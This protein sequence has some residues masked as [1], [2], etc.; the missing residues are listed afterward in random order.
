MNM[1]HKIIYLESWKLC[2]LWTNKYEKSIINHEIE[3]VKLEAKIT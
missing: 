3:I 2:K 1:K